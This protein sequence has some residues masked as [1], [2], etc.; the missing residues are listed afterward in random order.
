M[1][2]EEIRRLQLITFT[3]NMETMQTVDI[4]TDDRNKIKTYLLSGFVESHPFVHK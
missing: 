2:Q 4:V 3:E 1:F